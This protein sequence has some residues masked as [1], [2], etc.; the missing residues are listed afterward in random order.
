MKTIYIIKATESPKQYLRVIPIN[1][2]D[3]FLLQDNSVFLR[4]ESLK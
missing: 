4:L 2:A 1:N 3:S